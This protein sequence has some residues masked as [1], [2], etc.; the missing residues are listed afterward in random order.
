LKIKSMK[1]YQTSKYILLL[2]VNILVLFYKPVYA[3]TN[4]EET[5]KVDSVLVNVPVIVT[6]KND[7]FAQNLTINDFSIYSDKKKQVV[8]VFETSEA[9][10][11]V[12][13]MLDV[14]ISIGK[15]FKD[16][17]NSAIDFVKVLRPQDQAMMVTFG[18]KVQILN[19][20]TSDF[21]ILKSSIDKI[22]NTSIS[23]NT[24]VYDCLSEIIENQFK[25][26]DKS[27]KAIILLT[28]GVDTSSA[29]SFSGLRYSLA[30]SSIVIYTILY[31]T[32]SSNKDS[33]NVIDQI[34]N[35][36]GGRKFKAEKSNV[37]KVFKEI[38]KE[39]QNQYQLGFYPDDIDGDVLHSIKVEVT[40]QNLKVR[41]RSSYYIKK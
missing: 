37:K 20:F 6:D 16:I 19:D 8:S 24:S 10:L 5:I 2:L 41:T 4:D 29:R 17:Q 7:N 23:S 21:N 32:I 33:E 9:P 13:I 39:L 12:V 27:R 38:T 11:Q 36:T 31:Q 35:F 18:G 28:D 15:H 26:S 34:V 1:N 14:S 40:R 30:N 3:Q 25:N 22:S